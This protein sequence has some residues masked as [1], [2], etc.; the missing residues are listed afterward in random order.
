[1][2]VVVLAQSYDTHTAPI[3]WALQQAGYK[4]ACWGGLSWKEK[5]QASMLLNEQSKIVLGDF[6]VEP[7]D[8]IW[9]RRP[10]FPVLN[11]NVAE[12]DKKFAELEYRSFFYCIAYTLEVLP[13]R[14]INKFT[15]SRFINNKS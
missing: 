15:A 7:G 11:P 12:A 2:K 4:V 6:A 9:I 10:D 13:V 14:V 8:S 3:K 1:M 5:Q